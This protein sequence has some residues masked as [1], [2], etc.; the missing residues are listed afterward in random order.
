M[1]KICPQCRDEFRQSM[2]E[3][4][5]CHVTL[6]F[7]DPNAPLPP[8]APPP[9]ALDAPVAIH[10]DTPWSLEAV[11]R[12]LQEASIPSLIDVF[13]PGSEDGA[14]GTNLAL[15]VDAAHSD[16]AR[17]VVDAYTASRMPDHE[18][19]GEGLVMT[20]CPA[21]ATPLSGEE[22]A[23]AECGLEF[24]EIEV[25]CA[26]CGHTATSTAP[27]CGNCGQPFAAAE[28]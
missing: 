7:F 8:G 11:A 4:P 18:G 24:P 12:L 5:D 14:R 20:E 26:G 6:E 25:V 22:T 3:C 21:C 19:S 1:L 27:R 15:Y 16:A 10:R 28:G 2:S 9:P 17:A 13:P 23:C